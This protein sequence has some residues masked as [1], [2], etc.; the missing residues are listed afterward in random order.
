MD[1]WLDRV[2]LLPVLSLPVLS[3]TSSSSASHSD[4]KL[5]SSFTLIQLS[6]Q[7]SSLIQN[8]MGLLDHMMKSVSQ[9]ARKIV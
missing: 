9:L 6:P 4:S 1:V 7:L 3:T 8:L 2:K 5:P